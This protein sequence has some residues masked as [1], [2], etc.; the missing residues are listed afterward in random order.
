MDLSI[1]ST[2]KN[3]I[4]KFQELKF[5]IKGLEVTPNRKNVREK[6]CALTNSKEENLVV[7]SINHKFGSHLILGTARI[8][9][10]KQAMQK[11]EPKYMMERNFGK[12]EKKAAEPKS[13]EKK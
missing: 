12:A 4:L 10:S 6:I 2:E 7:K 9:E 11:T 13:E 8:Y 5:E 3:N 1:T